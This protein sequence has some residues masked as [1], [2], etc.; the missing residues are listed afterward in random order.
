MFYAF[1]LVVG[2]A[3]SL[4]KLGALSV[5]V[6]VLAGMVVCLAAVLAGLVVLLGWRAWRQRR[7]PL[8]ST[9]VRAYHQHNSSERASR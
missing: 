9:P 8:S 1:L 3:Y 7:Y 4:I 5:W 6:S 2:L